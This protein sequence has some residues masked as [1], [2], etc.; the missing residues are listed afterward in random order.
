MLNEFYKSIYI[1]VSKTQWHF[2]GYFKVFKCIIT[3]A[4]PISLPYSNNVP[5][6]ITLVNADMKIV[7]GTA[8]MPAERSTIILVTATSTSG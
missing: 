5:V 4:L 1:K 3:S 8:G 7:V 2:Y 6:F